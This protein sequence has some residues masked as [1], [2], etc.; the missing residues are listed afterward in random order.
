MLYTEV[1]VS[2]HICCPSTAPFGPKCPS[3]P[4]AENGPTE[5]D[6]K[7]SPVDGLSCSQVRIFEIEAPDLAASASALLPPS[8]D[9]E[10]ALRM[11]FPIEKDDYRRLVPMS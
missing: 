10:E 6:K 8:V 4:G 11:E 9:H 7:H 5:Q 2:L 3:P 1:G